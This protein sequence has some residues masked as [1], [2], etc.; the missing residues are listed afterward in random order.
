MAGSS[1][2]AVSTA[3]V[4]TQNTDRVSQNDLG[5]PKHS[6]TI[7]GNKQRKRRQPVQAGGCGRMLEKALT[8]FMSWQQVMDERYMSLEE[9]RLQQE[10][11]TEEHRIQQEE[12]R[13]QQLREHELRVI[14]LLAGAFCAAK[15]GSNCMT[16]D[17]QSVLGHVT[18]QSTTRTQQGDPGVTNTPGELVSDP[19]IN[20]S[21]PGPSKLSTVPQTM[22]TGQTAEED[23]DSRTTSILNSTTPGSVSFSVSRT[24]SCSAQQFSSKA[25]LLPLGSG[26]LKGNPT[27]KH[28]KFLSQRGNKIWLHKG[29]LQEGFTQYHVNK[30]D[31][32]CNPDVSLFFRVLTTWFILGCIHDKFISNSHGRLCISS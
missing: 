20:Q 21:T 8:S 29:I 12:R 2:T 16:V 6:N 9:R 23:G 32:N 15:G 17:N 10:A 31:E 1:G 27:F 13:A 25:S 7:K 4:P 5:D 22:K 26:L 18:S 24:S 30:Y 11:R 3:T 28:S 14:S 19:F